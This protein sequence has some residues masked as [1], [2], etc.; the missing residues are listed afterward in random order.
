MLPTINT[1]KGTRMQ[2]SPGTCPIQRHSSRMFRVPA[3]TERAASFDSR[4]WPRWVAIAGS[5][6]RACC[7]RVHS[8][9]ST[10][11]LPGICKV[12]TMITMRSVPQAS[13]RMRAM[14]SPARLG[15]NHSYTRRCREDLERRMLGE[16]APSWQ[17]SWGTLYQPGC[18]SC[19]GAPPLCLP[20]RRRFNRHML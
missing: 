20:C 4:F 17:G 5:T 15:A 14:S 12:I 13:A 18:G 9:F 6:M 1:I 8:G 11:L 10:S 3:F 7:I 2:I 16:D 19:A